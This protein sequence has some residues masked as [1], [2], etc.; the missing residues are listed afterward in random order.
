MKDSVKKIEG[1]IISNIPE[2]KTKANKANYN[3]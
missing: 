1:I 2:G 3:N